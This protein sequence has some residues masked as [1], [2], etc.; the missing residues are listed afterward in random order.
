MR[1]RKLGK[2][3]S[4]LVKFLN[5]RADSIKTMKAP[6][7]WPLTAPTTPKPTT[8]KIK[9]NMYLSYWSDNNS[10][11]SDLT[12]P[13]TWKDEYVRVNKNEDKIDATITTAA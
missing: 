7:N 11:A 5:N 12:L 6:A 3:G 1:W 4:F 9:D 10:I 2:R 13:V 8:T